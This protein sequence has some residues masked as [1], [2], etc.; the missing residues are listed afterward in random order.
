MC[1]CGGDVREPREVDRRTRDARRLVKQWRGIETQEGLLGPVSLPGVSCSG[2]VSVDSRLVRGCKLTFTAVTES[3]NQR[4]S[5]AVIGAGGLTTDT[6]EEQHQPDGVAPWPAIG[7]PRA[8]DDDVK[9][10]E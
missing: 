7:R 5:G 1:G 2:C 9:G 8:V 6:T 3:S 4:C 10:R